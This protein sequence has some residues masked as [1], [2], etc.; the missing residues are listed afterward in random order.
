MNINRPRRIVPAGPLYTD[1]VREGR[2]CST[3]CSFFYNF[4]FETDFMGAAAGSSTAA[5]IN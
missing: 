1:G 3:Y 5:A 4:F 2:I